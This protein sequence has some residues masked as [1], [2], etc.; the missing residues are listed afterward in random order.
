MNK[1]SCL[2][3]LSCLLGVSFL[4]GCEMIG[5]A[6]GIETKC[7]EAQQ[8][9]EGR[10]QRYSGHQSIPFE[11]AGCP[12][13]TTEIELTATVQGQD[14]VMSFLTPERQPLS[15]GVDKNQTG[16]LKGAVLTKYNE[17]TQK[18]LFNLEFDSG[19]NTSTDLVYSFNYQTNCQ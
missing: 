14:T 11:I 6:E 19:D 10:I 7:N 4:T 1:K 16:I 12:A 2:F 15:Y 3:L 8:A 17:K 13:M 9:C 18:G 5:D